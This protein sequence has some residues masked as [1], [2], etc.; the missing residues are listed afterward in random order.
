MMSLDAARCGFPVD[1]ASFGLPP[2]PLSMPAA[3]NMQMTLNRMKESMPP[4]TKEHWANVAAMLTATSRMTSPD[5][6]PEHAPL[7]PLDPLACFTP[8]MSAVSANIYNTPG[9]EGKG[10][11]DVSPFVLETSHDEKPVRGDVSPFLLE[12]AATPEFT[13][14]E[15]E[16]PVMVKAPPLPETTVLTK[17]EPSNASSLLDLADDECDAFLQT[18]L[19]L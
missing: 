15:P 16:L 12:P 14:P 10:G 6:E 8:P 4:A 7:P 13:K 2:R 19:T 18:L 5:H 9:R 11:G 3:L 17:S 1:P